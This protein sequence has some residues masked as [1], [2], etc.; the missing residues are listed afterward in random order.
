SEVDVITRYLV[1]DLKLVPPGFPRRPPPRAP[2]PAL[3]APV[4]LPTT[5]PPDEEDDLDLGALA[6]VQPV[7]P[8]LSPEDQ[9]AEALG[10]ELLADRCSRCHT[11]NR[12]FDKID[13]L[14]AGEAIIARMRKK[15][16]S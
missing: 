16:G 9:E 2:P 14:A 4:T 11:L 5:P 7:E 1:N 12:V 13:S 6:A 8:V 10:P 15:T 3:A